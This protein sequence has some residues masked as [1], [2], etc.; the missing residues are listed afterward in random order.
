MVDAWRVW[1]LEFY[2]ICNE[3]FSREKKRH[4]SPTE[5]E[6]GARVTGYDFYA[7]Q[8]VGVSSSTWAEGDKRIQD[9]LN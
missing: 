1:P 5:N 3:H 8:G 4:Y 9:T 6:E 2:F 7:A